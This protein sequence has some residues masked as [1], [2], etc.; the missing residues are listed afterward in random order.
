MAVW[1]EKSGPERYLNRRTD[2]LGDLLEIEGK[3]EEGGVDSDSK[4]FWVDV[5]DTH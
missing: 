5:D 2:N 3:E 4:I 1:P